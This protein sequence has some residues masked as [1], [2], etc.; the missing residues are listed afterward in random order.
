MWGTDEERRDFGRIWVLWNGS[1]HDRDRARGLGT[2][3][4]LA[5]HG[6]TPAVYGLAAAHHWGDGVKTDVRTAWKLYLAAANEGYPAAE[7]AVGNFFITAEPRH[8]V[9]EYSCAEAVSWHRRAAV[10]GNA[11]A[12]YNLAVSYWTGRGIEREA[13]NAFLWSG[14]AVHCSPIRLRPAE[15]L[16][17]EAGAAL[18]AAARAEVETEAAEWRERLPLPW[19][20]HLTYWRHLA[21]SAGVGV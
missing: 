15:T 14:L 17:D 20:E 5:D 13:R 16:R 11:G 12:A 21:R 2:L 18:D 6:Y 8:S 19:S 10:Q 7:A 3:R 4:K 1:P 9:C